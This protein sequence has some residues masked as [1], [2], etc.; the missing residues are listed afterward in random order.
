[1]GAALLGVD[2]GLAVGSKLHVAERATALSDPSDR[3]A[4]DGNHID[5]LS[6][7][8]AGRVKD[9]FGVGR[10]SEAIDG[11]VNGV[12]EYV[13]FRGFP[14]EDRQTPLVAFIAGAKLCPISQI[15]SIRRIDR[16]FI[17]AG[18]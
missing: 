11:V 5:G 17:G 16:P 18:I 1:M 12:G 14:L 9:E 15:P 3:P 7:M 4:I 8:V 2:H 6:S 10:E 13:E